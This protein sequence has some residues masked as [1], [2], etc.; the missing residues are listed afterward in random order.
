MYGKCSTEKLKNFRN[1]DDDD[2]D[3]IDSDKHTFR[4]LRS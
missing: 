2:G 3:D 4:K 1:A